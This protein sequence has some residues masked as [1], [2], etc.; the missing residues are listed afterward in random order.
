VSSA[1]RALV[2]SVPIL[3]LTSGLIFCFLRLAFDLVVMQHPPKLLDL[4]LL[5]GVL[6]FMLVALL[7]QFC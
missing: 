6:P 4:P 1:L 2:A 3:I 5:D 7:L